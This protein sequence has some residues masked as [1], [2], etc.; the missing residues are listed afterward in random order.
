[1]LTT[2]SS[3]LKG[4]LMVR[5]HVLDPSFFVPFERPPIIICGFA[6][7]DN[8]AS[9][10]ALHCLVQPTDVSLRSEPGLENSRRRRNLPVTAKAERLALSSQV[11]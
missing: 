11:A 5:V 2:M 9:T 4:F 3:R 1:M 8:V 7:T 10:Q 6:S